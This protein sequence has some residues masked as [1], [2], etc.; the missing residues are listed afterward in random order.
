[1]PDDKSTSAILHASVIAVASLLSTATAA[2]EPALRPILLEKGNLRV[3][4]SSNEPGPVKIA[5][6]ALKKD[7]ASIFGTE[8]TISDEMNAD[9]SQPEI[10][11][12]NRASK[13]LAVP[14]DKARALDD[15][16]SHRIYADA[17]SNRIYVE[18]FDDRGTIFAMFT[19]SESVLGVPPLHHWSSWVSVPRDRISVPPN[20]DIFFKS[21]QVRYRSLLPGDQDFFMPWKDAS[22]EHQNIW[23]ET[24]LRLKLNTVEAYNTIIP[25]YKL[26]K[27]AQLID[28][29]GLVLTSH[30][31]AGLNTSFSTWRDYWEKVRTMEPPEYRLSN[32][33]AIQDFFRHNAET[34]AQSGIENLWTVAFRGERDQPFWSIFTDAPEGDE[35]RANIINDMMQ[36][37][38]DLIK[39]MT[40]EEEP[41]ARITAYDEIADLLAAGLIQPPASENMIWTFVAAR[42]DHYPY[43]DIVHFDPAKPVKLGYYM[44]FGFAST[45]AH[46]APAEGPW[47]M[48]FN[49]RYVNNKSPLYF[50]V[51]NVGNMRKF[52]LELSAHAA[53]MWDYDS[54]STDDFVKE[55]SKLYFGEE[56]AVAI[57]QLYADYYDAYW[58]P[59]ES[60]FE[61]LK[62]Q[63]LFQ[64]LRY[65][66]VFDQVY[67]Q[68]FSS[69]APDLNP[70]HDIGYERMP[71]RSFRI[72]LEQN[73]AANEVDAILNGMQQT[74]HR[75]ETVATRC[76][77]MM[78]ALD[79]DK[80]VFFNDNLRVFSYYMAHLSKS[81]YHYL[82]AYKH[83]ADSDLLIRHLNLAHTEAVRAAVSP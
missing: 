47:K 4:F 3:V 79:D 49:Y 66:R 30:H 34:V 73:N 24:T 48:E 38:Y 28:K 53:M 62:R 39:E 58:E 32:K 15:F 55:Y 2:R 68:F 25:P 45:G 42:R 57:A 14:R 61:G 76:S 23:L 72:D 64:D 77:E 20:T 21:P 10:V 29:Y 13:S 82:Y 17:E 11:I 37:Q 67:P 59:K 8:P 51:V 69:P 52:L 44:N 75:F 31:T 54:Y 83:Q 35:A 50:S 6:E 78:L 71:G 16:E 5:L 63:F 74:I 41:Y 27:Y 56:H 46:V 80:Q 60:E 9:K 81:L 40:G 19:F 18:G 12:V 26:S 65:A 22:V 33:Q 43:D 7:F 70:L 36:I 1:M